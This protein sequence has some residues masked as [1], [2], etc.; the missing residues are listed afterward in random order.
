MFDTGVSWA[1]LKLIYQTHL[2][3]A[4]LKIK[5][6]TFSG[7]AQM[8][9]VTKIIQTATQTHPSSCRVGWPIGLNR[10]FGFTE[11]NKHLSGTKLTQETVQKQ[12][13]C[14]KLCKLVL[15][16]FESEHSRPTFIFFV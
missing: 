8:G 15:L 16:K 3:K 1:P 4:F 10:C 11:R 6:I 9:F 2:K 14:L 5:V 13:V 7:E 12:D